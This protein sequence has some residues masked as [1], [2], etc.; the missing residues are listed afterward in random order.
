MATLLDLSNEILT[1]ILEYVC[2]LFTRHSD[3]TCDVALVCRRLRLLARPLIFSQVELSMAGSPFEYFVR[4]ID[5]DPALV[6][7]VRRLTLVW[8][9]RAKNNR[10]NPFLAR[11]TSVRHLYLHNHWDN[12]PSIPWYP[13][14]LED[15]GM[16]MLQSIEVLRSTV[17][18]TE[19]ALYLSV[20]S[21]RSL[22]LPR[23]ACVPNFKWPQ[24]IPSRESFIEFL[25][26]GWLNMEDLEG[27]LRGMRALRH[28]SI[29]CKPKKHPFSPAQISKILSLVFETLESLV[30]SV[31]K[32]FEEMS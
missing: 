20:P 17:S 28:L 10:A 30:I 22:K 1:E 29:W 8:N 7:M 16:P 11:F 25:Q 32:S 15:G 2:T 23:N 24:E 31:N 4:S 9:H 12:K 19:L 18:S 26:I 13:E 14:F 21:L 27:V 3:S 6:G 5:E